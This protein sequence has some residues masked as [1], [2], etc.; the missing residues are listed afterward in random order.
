M[1]WPNDLYFGEKKLG[2]VLIEFLG[3]S[4]GRQAVVIGMGLNVAMPVSAA[5]ALDRPWT[6]LSK[7]SGQDIDRNRLGAEVL[8]QLAM[9]LPALDSAD[10]AAWLDRWR[11]RDFLRGRSVVV[12]GSPPVAGMRLASMTPGL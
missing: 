2:G 10:S 9:G 12:E 11:R 4:H 6:D 3:E 1:K 8:D 5:V 7:A